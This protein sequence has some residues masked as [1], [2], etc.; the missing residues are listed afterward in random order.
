MGLFDNI[1]YRI[2]QSL[3][4]DAEGEEQKRFS[5]LNSFLGSSVGKD[6]RLSWGTLLLIAVAVYAIVRLFIVIIEIFG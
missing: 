1:K 4:Q 5:K 2:N 3:V 6:G